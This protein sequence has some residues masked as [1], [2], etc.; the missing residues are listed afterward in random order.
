MHET[1]EKTN[2][3]PGT[4]CPVDGYVRTLIAD[5][6]SPTPKHHWEELEPESAKSYPRYR[7]RDADGNIATLSCEAN[8]ATHS[9]Y[10]LR[11]IDEES[12]R[13][14]LRTGKAVL[15]AARP[16]PCCKA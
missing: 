3:A 12:R 16:V 13:T 11:V 9:Q 14:P 6:Q 15:S 10:T 2:A 1:I 5:A 8:E 4:P 7:L